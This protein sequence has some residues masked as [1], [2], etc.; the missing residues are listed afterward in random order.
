MEQQVDRVSTYSISFTGHGAY[1]DNALLAN[2][3]AL[4]PGG[5]GGS[6]LRA[7]QG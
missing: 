7:V 4:K 2:H 5:G 1:E 6:C 3:I